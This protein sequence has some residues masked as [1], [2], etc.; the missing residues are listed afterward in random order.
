MM[1]ELSVGSAGIGIWPKNL[2]D[3]ESILGFW[4]MSE[5]RK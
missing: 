4:K 2:G 1:L 3:S 5:G